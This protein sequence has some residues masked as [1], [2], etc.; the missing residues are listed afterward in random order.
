MQPLSFKNEDYN[1]IKAA[2]LSRGIFYEDE[3]FTNVVTSLQ[4][5]SGSIPDKPQFKRPNDISDNAVL[6]VDGPPGA[7]CLGSLSNVNI[8][9]AMSIVAERNKFLD[10]LFPDLKE[11]NT[12]ERSTGMLG[13]FDHLENVRLEDALEDLT[14]CVLDTL[15][16]NNL[17]GANDLRRIQTFEVLEHALTDGAIILLCTKSKLTSD[18][19]EH[20]LAPNNGALSANESGTSFEELCA[21][22]CLGCVDPATGLCSN[23]AYMLTKTCLVPRDLSVK[24]AVLSAL[25]ITQDPPKERLLR[26]RSVLTVA[27]KSS[28]FGEWKG[29]YSDSSKEWEDLTVNQRTRIGLVISTEAEFW[30]PLAA[31]VEFFAGG[32]VCLL[33]KTGLFNQWTLADYHGSWPGERSGGGLGFRKSF[34]QNPQYMFQVTKDTPEEVLVSLT[35]KYTWN[36][37]TQSIVEEPSPPPIGFGLLKVENNREVRAHVLS[38]CN[39]VDV[40]GPKPHRAIFGRYHLEKGRYILVPFL[41]EPQQEANYYLRLFFP[42]SLLSRELIHDQPPRGVFALFTSSPIIITRV[43]L[44]KG[45]NL[46]RLNSRG[47]PS[48]YCRVSCEGSSCCSQVKTSNSNP[49]WNDSFV[50]YRSKPTKQPIKLEVFD[51][52]TIGADEFLGECIIN[53]PEST[54]TGDFDLDLYSKPTGNEGKV[55]LKGTIFV[56]IYTVD[57]ENYMDI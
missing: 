11:L 52:H 43:E 41:E 31:L 48:P 13:G 44:R 16:F 54:G 26:L 27:S 37:D 35:R 49:K 38:L 24:G 28:S 53:T 45:T 55:R 5:L 15:S 17:S 40:R 25:K 23:Y 6:K 20:D 34:L 8:V 9:L 47:A 21:P 57:V 22:R 56:S 32:I 14:G 19:K 33:P 1:K 7:I 51:K 50:F 36:S 46:A 18:I 39:I 12:F 10:A 3:T 42:R 29:S 2:H 30:M 4:S